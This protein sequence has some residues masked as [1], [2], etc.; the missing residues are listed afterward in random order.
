MGNAL[1]SQ[2]LTLDGLRLQPNQVEYKTKEDFTILNVDKPNPLVC[3]VS[4]NAGAGLGKYLVS[5]LK[6]ILTPIQ[7]FDLSVT[8]PKAA[9]HHF[10]DQK[11]GE[12]I[13][14]QVLIAGGDGTVGWVMAE[15]VKLTSTVPSVVVLPLGTGN[16]L[17]RTLGWG[18]GFDNLARIRE[19]LFDILQAKL[20]HLD[21]WLITLSGSESSSS[22]E[23]YMNNYFSLG[24]DASICLEYHLSRE[25][26][27]KYNSRTCNKCTYA[28][29]GAQRVFQ[30][31]APSITQLVEY[32]QV[33]GERIEIQPQWKG[34]I[35]SNLPS[36]SSGV[37]LWG[38]RGLESEGLVHQD[39][40]DGK[41]EVMAIQGPLH[42]A[43][44]RTSTTHAIR[45][46]QGKTVTISLS[47]DCDVQVDGEPWNQ[48]S[49]CII[50][51]QHFMRWP[52]L[53][54]YN[55]KN[56]SRCLC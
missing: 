8:V 49:P 53:K 20:I 11:T 9:L 45:L 43:I 7:V 21:R 22:R 1:P 38:T 39:I 15:L 2:P 55:T 30:K 52:M 16:D 56:I 54:K 13:P 35:I 12:L 6:T 40:S 28:Q 3:F 31:D 37:D 47:Q 26:T 50:K 41:L 46:A 36:Y 4:P 27:S 24:V 17:A 44:L 5:H 10:I 33:D 25:D 51:L 18:G 42:L 32:I 19:F 23:V 14:M 34:I 48:T 29:I